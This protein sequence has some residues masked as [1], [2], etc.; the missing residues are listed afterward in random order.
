MGLSLENHTNTA[1][2]IAHSTND[3]NQP[4]LRVRREEGMNH[5]AVAVLLGS[6]LLCF[7]FSDV[8]CHNIP[9][10]VWVRA[11]VWEGKCARVRYNRG[12]MGLFWQ[13]GRQQQQQQQQWNTYMHRVHIPCSTNVYIVKYIQFQYVFYGME[14]R[15]LAKG[16][17]RTNKNFPSLVSN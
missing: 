7:F 3:L 4:A 2:A 9:T 6:Y 8:L 15:S 11:W 1:Q 10:G 13:A 12:I 16:V 5:F 17:K 14:I